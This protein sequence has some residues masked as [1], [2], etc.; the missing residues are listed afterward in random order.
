MNRGAREFAFSRDDNFG[1]RCRGHGFD[2][3]KRN[4]RRAKH[5]RGRAAG[6]GA[7]TVAK[8]SRSIR[9]GRENLSARNW[10]RLALHPKRAQHLL[11]LAQTFHA[12]HNFLAQV[13]ALLKAHPP[14]QHATFVGQIR[15]AEIHQKQR[16]S[17]FNS[18]GVVGAPTH[19]PCDNAAA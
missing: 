13:A 14:R 12:R 18:R 4:A 19:W 1:A 5:G 7:N 6:D 2:H 11:G 17:P 16:R 15:L 8:I 10:Y 3:A 9:A